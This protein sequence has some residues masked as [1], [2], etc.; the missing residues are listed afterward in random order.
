MKCF[1][2]QDLSR[3]PEHTGYVIATSAFSPGRDPKDAAISH[4]PVPSTARVLR[5]ACKDG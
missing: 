3:L 1:F 4:V 2:T 5:S